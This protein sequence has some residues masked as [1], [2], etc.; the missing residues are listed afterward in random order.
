LGTLVS[1]TNKSDRHDI[2]EMLFKVATLNAC[3]PVIR[4]WP[5]VKT[6]FLSKASLN[7]LAIN[8]PLVFS[9]RYAVVGFLSG[10]ILLGDIESHD[11]L[12]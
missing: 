12:V 1:S 4:E 3:F 6:S 10:V 8:C 2:T 11:I 7:N 5:M 9:G